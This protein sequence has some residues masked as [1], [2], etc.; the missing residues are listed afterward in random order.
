MPSSCEDS[1]FE[2][3]GAEHE[4]MNQGSRGRFGPFVAH[5]LCAQFCK[6]RPHPWRTHQRLQFNLCSVTA[7]VHQFFAGKMF[8]CKAIKEQGDS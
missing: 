3:S 4:L 5:A 2:S 8:G 6:G 7:Y 1:N